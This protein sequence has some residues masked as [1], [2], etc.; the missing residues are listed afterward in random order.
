MSAGCVYYN[1]FTCNL[2]VCLVCKHK[3]FDSTLAWIWILRASETFCLIALC[4]IARLCRSS[5]ELK[6]CLK[7]LQDFGRKALF[8][9][10]L[11]WLSTSV[12]N[13]LFLVVFCVVSADSAYEPPFSQSILLVVSVCALA[14]TVVLLLNCATCCKEREINFK[15]SSTS[16]SQCQKPQWF[17]L[18]VKN[19]SSVWFL[20]NREKNNSFRNKEPYFVY[21][22][23]HSYNLLVLLFLAFWFSWVHTLE[24]YV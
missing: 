15:V 8:K 9:R 1:P 7:C 10:K 14:A 16:C 21:N 23:H 12:K 19:L 4:L 24:S 17:L 5:R 22:C 11:K 2:W 13:K 20:N 6:W 18:L 3:V